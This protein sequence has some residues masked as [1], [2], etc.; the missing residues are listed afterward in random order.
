MTCPIQVCLNLFLF[1]D[2]TCR[3]NTN[4]N[5]NRGTLQFCSLMV[6]VQ[7][8]QFASDRGMLPSWSTLPHS[9]M[10]LDQFWQCPQPKQQNVT[11]MSNVRCRLLVQQFSNLRIDPTRWSF[12]RNNSWSFKYASERELTWEDAMP[13]VQCTPADPR[14]TVGL[15]EFRSAIFAE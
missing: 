3:R 1:T 8:R 2:Y 10:S 13:S 14:A 11:V 5:M 15:P 12:N 7:L 6:V 4:S 9:P